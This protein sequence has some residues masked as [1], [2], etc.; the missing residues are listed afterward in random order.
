MAKTETYTR[1]LSD[2]FYPP[3]FHHLHQDV[4]PVS[5]R[6]TTRTWIAGCWSLGWWPKWTK[7]RRRQ[8]SYKRR[9]TG[10]GG[11]LQGWLSFIAARSPADFASASH[12]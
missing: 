4:Q 10:R 8:G 7:G 9:E 11:V 3:R 6:R 2:F 5:R 12:M 1:E